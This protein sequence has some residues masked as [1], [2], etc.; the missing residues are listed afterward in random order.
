MASISHLIYVSPVRLHSAVQRPH[1][2][3]AWARQRWGCTVTW[4]DPYPVRLPTARDIASLYGDSTSHQERLIGPLWANEPWLRRLSIPAIPFDPIWA[5]RRLNRLLR[6]RLVEGLRDDLSDAA[7]TLLAVGR[8]CELALQLVRIPHQRSLYDVMDDM[9][10]FYKG[11]SSRWMARVH[12]QLLSECDMVWC[13]SSRL[14]QDAMARGRTDC[15][16]VGNAGPGCP[17]VELTHRPRGTPWVA[18]YVGTLGSWFDWKCLTDWAMQLPDIRWELVG[19]L[20]ADVPTG[21]PHNV[22]L[23]G[24]LPHQDVMKTMQSGWDVGLI[25]FLN[26][27]LTHAVD[28]VK[29]YEYR[30]S[31]LPVLSSRFGEMA[32]KTDDDGVWLMD[33][34]APAALPRQLNRWWSQPNHGA[35]PSAPDWLMTWPRRFDHGARANMGLGITRTIDLA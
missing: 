33:E 9:P 15:V 2:F 28:P 10:Q 11:I 7:R 5:G 3:V 13:S 26:T 21:L 17:S 32:H 27:A 34:L 20:S 12:A 8:P 23:L 30:Q 24:P 16:L 22:K 14:L 35:T 19:A 4:I 1:H 6:H 25:P 29:Y 31:G 18:G